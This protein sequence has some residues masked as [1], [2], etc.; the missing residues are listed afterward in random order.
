M[1]TGLLALLLVGG[2]CSIRLRINRYRQEGAAARLS[3]VSLALQDLVAVAGGIY[4]SLIMLVSFLKVA[5]PEK[6][7]IFS[8]EV[9]PL[10][11]FSLCMG[12]VQPMILILIKKV[13]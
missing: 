12:I 13:K 8:L 2:F 6:I 3:P 11:F 4:L 9:D 5:V 7:L 10:A 1:G